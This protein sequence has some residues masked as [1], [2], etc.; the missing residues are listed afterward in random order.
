MDFF[1]R[2]KIFTS[3]QCSVLALDENCFPG[4]QGFE[5]KELV[6]RMISKPV[7]SSRY[8]SEEMLAITF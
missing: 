2:C 1:L 6:L 8:L 7:G 4:S 5:A 3:F